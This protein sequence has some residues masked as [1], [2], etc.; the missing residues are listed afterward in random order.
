M[1]LLDLPD[2]FYDLPAGKLVNVATY[3]EMR[4]P[5]ARSLA[6]IKPPFHLAPMD[7]G[8]LGG[9]RALYRQIGEAWLWFSR[10]VMSDSTVAAILSHPAVELFALCEGDHRLGMLELDFRQKGNCELAFLGLDTAAIGR[11]L[12]R[13]LMDEAIRRAFTRPINRF[14]L[15]TD[16][17]DSPNALPFY[18]RSG[19]RP[20]ARQIE[21]HDDHR[22][23]GKLRRTQRRTSQSSGD[24]CRP[25]CRRAWP[26]QERGRVSCWKQGA[27]MPR[28]RPSPGQPR[29]HSQ[30]AEPGDGGDSEWGGYKPHV[31]GKLSKPRRTGF[32]PLGSVRP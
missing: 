22:L 28:L 11:E 5:P 27:P 15:R 12:G 19:F 23:T 30:S 14:W 9:Y 4:E 3:L 8:D 21:I 6:S 13:A 16:T 17:F 26:A 2:R 20:Y 29:D 7:G 10:A 32:K 24:R 1:P 31:N 18:I 25:A